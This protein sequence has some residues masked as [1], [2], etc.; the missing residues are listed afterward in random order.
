MQKRPENVENKLEMRDVLPVEHHYKATLPNDDE[1]GVVLPQEK[2][3]GPSKWNNELEAEPDQSHESNQSCGD[4][5]S[6]ASHREEEVI[7]IRPQRNKRPPVWLAD[8]ITGGELERSLAIQPETE[9]LASHSVKMAQ[10]QLEHPPAINIQDMWHLSD[11]EERRERRLPGERLDISWLSDSTRAAITNIFYF[12][13]SRRQVY[14]GR[15]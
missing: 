6:P 5:A 14:S 15:L 13:R 11:D 12:N 3:D 7:S 4:V 9:T 2:E 1:M 8:F 10:R